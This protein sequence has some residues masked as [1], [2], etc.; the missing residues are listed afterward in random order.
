M[1]YN[2][3]NLIFS[4]LEVLFILTETFL[5]SSVY[6]GEL[7]P[8][9]YTVLRKDRD[10]DVGWGGV[11]LAARSDLILRPITNIDGLT[12]EMELLISHG[13]FK[14]IKFIC[15]VVYLPPNYKDEQYINVLC[16]IENVLCKYSD[17]DVIITGDFNLSSC[18]VTV[19]THFNLFCELCDVHQFN[20]V[21]NEYGGLLDLVLTGMGRDLLAVE[22]ASDALVPIDR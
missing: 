13:S 4:G 9:G 1:G 20:D 5:T 2:K 14:N 6:D 7:F 11:L 15:C 17:I 19:R 22:C 8:S 21:L 18:S 12:S 3:V 10:G 16:C